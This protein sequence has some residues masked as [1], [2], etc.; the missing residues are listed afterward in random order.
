MSSR[1]SVPDS[2]LA[3][4]GIDGPFPT[5]LSPP[6]SPGRTSYILAVPFEYELVALTIK[7]NSSAAS[8][9]LVNGAP[10]V[11]KLS[12]AVGSNSV[13]ITVTAQDPGVTTN[14]VVDIQRD[15]PGQSMLD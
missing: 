12:L 14:Y 1:D 4:L 15:G 7:A 10:P 6:L 5:H 3:A 8:L 13:F 9:I 11:N 2:S